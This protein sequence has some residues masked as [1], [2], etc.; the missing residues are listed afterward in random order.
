[1]DGF[2]VRLLAKVEAVVVVEDVTR[3]AIG[4]VN[5]GARIPKVVGV[6]V[7]ICADFRRRNGSGIVE[8][9][10]VVRVDSF[11]TVSRRGKFRS[12]PLVWL[13]L[14]RDEVRIVEELGVCR[15]SGR[16]EPLSIVRE[17]LDETGIVELCAVG[18]SHFGNV[19]GVQVRV[20]RL[21]ES[22]GGIVG[23]EIDICESVWSV[24]SI[25]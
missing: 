1:M 3:V 6:S 22:S 19:P 7:E 15:V 9:L 12:E 2:G 16:D 13:I 18:L 20:E 4:I 8:K 11:G 24:V 21:R 17:R 14:G 10:L 25:T 5:R 23:V